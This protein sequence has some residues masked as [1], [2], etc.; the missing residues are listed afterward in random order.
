MKTILPIAIS[1]VLLSVACSKQIT[2]LEYN[3]SSLETGYVCDT[4]VVN[5]PDTKTSYSEDGVS[6]EKNDL[7]YY[8]SMPNGMSKRNYKITSAG[9]ST[10]L[11]LTRPEGDTCYVLVHNGIEN[12]LFKEYGNTMAFSGINPKQDGTFKSANISASYIKASS[13][14]TIQMHNITALLEFAIAREDV[15]I[16]EF[17]G[18]NSEKVNG[19]LSVD[20]TTNPYTVSRYGNYP[21]AGNSALDTISFTSAPSAN[22]YYFNIMPQIFTKGF[23]ISYYGTNSDGNYPIG[24]TS[25]SNEVDFS[26]GKMKFISGINAK[27]STEGIA[28]WHDW[29]VST[30]GNN[31]FYQKFAI[32]NN[33]LVD[34]G[35]NI[36]QG[37]YFVSDKGYHTWRVY[38]NRGKSFKI[39]SAEGY[40][41]NTVTFTYTGKNACVIQND[42]ITY[43]SESPITINGNSAT[44]DVVYSQSGKTSGSV[45]I[46]SIKVSYKKTN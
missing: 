2:P 3:E 15:R 33:I 11:E 6:W 7:I 8:Y 5:S 39:E 17:K 18:N 14:E 37:Y 21:N 43:A 22:P 12:P 25:T 41:I 20:L 26:A 42:G 28:K 44:F 23:T 9:N 29:T 46:T 34:S 40:T 32:D 16:V 30:S 27:Y 45:A 4:F 35:T 38:E 36:Q 24:T 1:C 31:Q 13:K 19:R 10:T